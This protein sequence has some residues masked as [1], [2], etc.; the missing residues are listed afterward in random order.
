MPDLQALDVRADV[1]IDRDVVPINTIVEPT[2]NQNIQI[3]KDPFFKTRPEST[4]MVKKVLMSDGQRDL[5]L[6]QLDSNGMIVE[7][8]IKK[9][10]AT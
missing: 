2:V 3:Y 1:F 10:V 9:E 6:V 8:W 4:A 7:R 5:C